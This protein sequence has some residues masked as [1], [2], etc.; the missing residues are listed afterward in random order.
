[1]QI[2]EDDDEENPVASALR[3][4][5]GIWGAIGAFGGADGGI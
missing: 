3:A 2:G 1:V 5:Q 4:V